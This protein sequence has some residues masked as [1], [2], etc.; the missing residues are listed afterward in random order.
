[1]ESELDQLKKMTNSSRIPLSPRC[2]TAL[3]LTFSAAALTSCGD[4]RTPRKPVTQEYHGVKVADAYQWLENGSDPAVRQWSSNQNHEARAYLDK[5]PPRAFVQDEL[6]RM[7]NDRGLVS[8][9]GRIHDE[10][11]KKLEALRSQ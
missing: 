2:I 1:M 10:I 6:K 7:L 8:T 11:L 5:L 3:L 4:N 9:N